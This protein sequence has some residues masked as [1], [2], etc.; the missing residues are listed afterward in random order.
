M[1]VKP[2]VIFARTAARRSRNSGF[3]NH[4]CRK[5]DPADEPD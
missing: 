4:N 5:T 2:S 1:A 3:E